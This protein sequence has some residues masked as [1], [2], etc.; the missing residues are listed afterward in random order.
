MRL[1]NRIS[2]A[3]RTSKNR[4]IPEYTLGFLGGYRNDVSGSAGAGFI[5]CEGTTQEYLPA[6]VIEAVDVSVSGRAL[7]S[8]RSDV[9]DVV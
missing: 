5:R 6:G 4:L 7:D 2:R 3:G 8:I 9:A 1:P